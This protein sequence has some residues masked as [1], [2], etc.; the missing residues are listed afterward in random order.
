MM[1]GTHLPGRTV[2][3]QVCAWVEMNKTILNTQT[4]YDQVAVEYAE[5]F[6]AA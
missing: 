6:K 3:G 5:K 2:P 1:I 4:S